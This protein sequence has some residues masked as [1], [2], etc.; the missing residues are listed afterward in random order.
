MTAEQAKKLAERIERR[1]QRL[2]P[3]KLQRATKAALKTIRRRIEDGSKEAALML[4]YLPHYPEIKLDDL[5]YQ[6]ERYG[7]KAREYPY[8]DILIVNW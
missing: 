5:K 2:Y 6:I 1:R 4:E 3:R 7:Y 8:G